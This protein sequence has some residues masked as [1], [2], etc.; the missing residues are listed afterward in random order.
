MAVIF[1]WSVHSMKIC[2]KCGSI[3]LP[4]KVDGK[5][6]FVCHCGYSETGESKIKETVKDMA[7]DIA[8]ADKATEIL[9]ETKVKCPDCSNDMAYFWEIQTRSPDE[10]ATMFFKCKKCSHIWR[11]YK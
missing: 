10:A 6:A 5:V 9:P 7:L 2:P 8:I 4:K 11:K 3:M 1:V